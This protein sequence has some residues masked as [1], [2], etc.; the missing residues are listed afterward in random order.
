[1][2]ASFSARSPLWQIV[3]TLILF[4]L[5]MLVAYS[6]QN[7]TTEFNKLDLFVLIAGAVVLLLFAA[8]ILMLIQYNRHHPENKVGLFGM[9]PIELKNE[10]EGMSMFTAHATQRVYKYYT[11]ALP[12]TALI[13]LYLPHSIY[14]TLTVLML[15]M[16]GHY[17]IYW[18][19][20]W[21]VFK[22]LPDET[23]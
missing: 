19:A 9:S 4:P 2:K 20:I 5:L 17:I 12:F 21:P 23:E 7:D 10:D 22:E 11:F 15:L 16:I 14:I 3:A 18:H 8:Y 6:R 13:L 1:M